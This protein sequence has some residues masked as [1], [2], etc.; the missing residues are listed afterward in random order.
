MP[1]GLADGIKNKYLPGIH[2]IRKAGPPAASAVPQT[3]TG[4]ALCLSVSLSHSESLS[5][6]LSFAFSPRFLVQRARHAR[7]PPLPPQASPDCFS[8]HA[9]LISPPSLPLPLSISLSLS[10]HISKGCPRPAPA[11]PRAGPRRAPQGRRAQAAQTNQK[12]A[13]YSGSPAILVQR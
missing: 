3:H 7:R 1:L 10:V 8:I 9:P 11:L 5:L 4:R 12:S 6:F 2:P 13:R